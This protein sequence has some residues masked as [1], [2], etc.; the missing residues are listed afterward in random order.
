MLSLKKRGRA[1]AVIGVAAL[2]GSLALATPAFAGGNSLAASNN[3]I[4]GSGSA[5]TYQVMTSLG[6]LFN[7]FP[8]CNM[9]VAAGSP[10]PLNY[11]CQPPANPNTAPYAE[12]PVND[13]AFQEPPLG[14]SNG[15]QQ[16]EYQANP[17][18]PVGVAPSN[19]ARSSRG[20]KGTDNAGLNFV[21]YAKDGVSWF[22]FTEVDGHP[23]ASAGVH[24]LTIAQLQAIATGSGSGGITN[25]K[26][27]G[28]TSAPILVFAAQAG[29]GTE[30]TWESAI[31]AAWSTTAIK[32][33]KTGTT[34]H[35][36][37]ENE[38]R[39]II[40]ATSTSPTAAN[41]IGNI[42]FLFSYGKYTVSCTTGPKVCGGTP[43]PGT[44]AT[45][46]T[47]TELGQINGVAPTTQ[48]I[49]C[50]TVGPTCPKGP[51]P[52]PRF[53]YNVYA[54][55]HAGSDSP[56]LSPATAAT[57]NFVSEAGFICK[58]NTGVADPVTGTSVRTE[59]TQTISGGG[60]IPLPSVANEDSGVN[61]PA[62][63]ANGSPYKQWDNPPNKPGFC[64]VT[65]TG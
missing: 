25:W 18:P 52:V 22:H 5:T 1:A 19:F 62:T 11:S 2:A 12:N 65:S 27:V 47:K 7:G 20:L 17:S 6:D 56:V 23:T 14:S 4:I 60:F 57:L 15:I 24:N 45:H 64:I 3:T 54:N 29:S 42:I 33:S 55:S 43:V 16:L 58:P 61:F 8:G 63:F 31:S 50:T 35:V 32:E 13:V 41:Y 59:I 44:S 40:Q 28:G 38:D 30:S 53:I 51:F 21:A 48:T 34:N 39:Q 9:I 49:L 46:P 10:Q 36:V 26:S 37:F